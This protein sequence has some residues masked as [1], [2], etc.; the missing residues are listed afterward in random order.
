MLSEFLSE[1]TALE[2]NQQVERIIK[3][4]LNPFEVLK[5]SP[6]M[7]P[8]EINTGYRKISLSV[9]PGDVVQWVM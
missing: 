4:R 2:R 1:T 5:C 3:Y 7:T 8:D 9:H 6:E